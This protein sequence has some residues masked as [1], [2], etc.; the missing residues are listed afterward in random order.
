MRS[1]FGR[2]ASPQ[3]KHRDQSRGDTEP[4]TRFR[5]RGAHRTNRER[6]YFR[7]YHLAVEHL[8]PLRR[9][10]Q[11]ILRYDSVRRGFSGPR[12][13]HTMSLIGYARVS[14]AEGRQVLDRQLDALN[15]AGCERVFDDHASGAAPERPN[16]TACL[17]YLRRGDVLV[18][19][20]LDRL[21][22][23]AGELITRIDELDQRGVE[24]RALNSPMDTTTPAG[25]AFLQIQ[26]AFAEME[27][28]VIRQRVR[29]GVKA[30]RARGRKGGRPRVMTPEKLRYAQNLMSDRTRS[31]P[32]ICRELGDL[33]TSTLSGGQCQTAGFSTLPT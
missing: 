25:R 3:R 29:E 2:P 6:E 7:V 17:D 20:D 15:A 10:A 18:V 31:I 23:R 30:A 1:T 5:Y 4:F 14:T 13:H 27:R 26:A 9:L 11:A 8:P 12:A 24:F 21:G 19:L 28:N 16:L 32:D 22:R 33:P